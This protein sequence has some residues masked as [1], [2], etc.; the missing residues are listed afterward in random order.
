MHWPRQRALRLTR[1][2][3]V[4]AAVALSCSILYS[5]GCALVT[6]V[7]ETLF[8]CPAKRSGKNR[9]FGSPQASH[10]VVLVP[11]FCGDAG[12]TWQNGETGFDLAQ[13]LAKDVHDS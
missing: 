7:G 10:L 4:I 2:L 9:Y 13:E 6:S 8:D 5:S 11:G 1:P 3:R 12:K